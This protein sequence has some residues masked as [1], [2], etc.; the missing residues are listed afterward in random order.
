MVFAVGNEKAS[1]AGDFSSAQLPCRIFPASQLDFFPRC[2]AFVCE[3]VA[4]VEAEPVREPSSGVSLTGWH[5]TTTATSKATNSFNC[6]MKLFY[7]T[8]LLRLV[9]DQGASTTTDSGHWAN[10]FRGGQAMWDARAGRLTGW[11]RRSSPCSRCVSKISMVTGDIYKYGDITNMCLI[12][13]IPYKIIQDDCFQYT[14]VHALYYIWSSNLIF[15]VGEIWKNSQLY[16]ITIM[17][18]YDSQ[19]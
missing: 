12:S 16:S 2:Q 9:V 14:F 4:Y 5:S 7:V 17:Y 8:P 10:W 15:Q 1:E 11:V 3:P 13:C 19:K 18:Y 6:N